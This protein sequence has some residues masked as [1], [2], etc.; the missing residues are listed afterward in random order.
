[1]R[2][3]KIF[4]VGVVGCGG[5]LPLHLPEILDNK[6]VSLKAL[7][8]T[9]E[10]IAREYARKLN[11]GAYKDLLSFLQN[12]QLDA[13]HLL[14]PP[15]TH[16]GVGIA[17][18]RAG[19][20]L[21]VEKPMALTK[22]DAEMLK[23]EAEENGRCLTIVHNHL[24]DPPFLAA[25]EHVRSGNFGKLLHMQVIYCLN[26]KDTKTKTTSP[27]HWVNHLPVKV[28]GEWLPHTVYTTRAFLEDINVTHVS[29]RELLERRWLNVHI[30]GTESTCDINIID[31]TDYELFHINLFME[32]SLIH[33]NMIDLTH[34]VMDK[35]TLPGVGPYMTSTFME[36]ILN[37]KSISGNALNMVLGKLKRKQTHRNIIRAFYDHLSG[38]GDNPVP[39]E[40]GIDVMRI[41]DDIRDLLY[42]KSEAQKK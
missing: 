19:C 31:N 28:F 6:R 20:H 25:K 37:M 17:V 11:C 29:M 38:E 42:M 4:R 30:S 8:D 14:S 2:N 27:E 13:V 32:S 5:A 15:H 1:M 39:P 10:D 35:R 21:L 33:L 12:E 18:L 41:I 7:C 3:N 34:R 22:A 24:F 23:T 36:S 40:E 9:N 16:V 26:R